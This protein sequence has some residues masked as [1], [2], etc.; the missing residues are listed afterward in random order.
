MLEERKASQRCRNFLK[1]EEVYWFAWDPQ[2]M[3]K[4][5]LSCSTWENEKDI[6]IFL[7]F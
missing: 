3:K 4:L 2:A 6:Y 7:D 1:T 5:C